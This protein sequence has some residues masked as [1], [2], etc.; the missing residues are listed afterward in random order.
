MKPLKI[1]QHSKRE[2]H[3]TFSREREKGSPSLRQKLPLVIYIVAFFTTASQFFLPEKIFENKMKTRLAAQS[4]TAKE[5]AFLAEQEPIYILP[6]YTMNGTELVGSNMPKLRAL[7]RTEVALWLA[8]LL[9]KQNKCSIVIPDWL[10]VPFL[11]AK[12]IE[13][14][15]R[16][17]RVSE[18]PWH[19]IPTSKILLDVCS[20]DFIDSP[21]EL[22]S[23]IQDLR[24]IRML[25][26]RQGF[27]MIDDEY[28]ELTGLSL[29]EIN[30]IRP[31]L[32]QTMNTL[33]DL[34]KVTLWD[35]EGEGGSGDKDRDEESEEEEEEEAEEAEANNKTHDSSIGS[36]SINN[37]VM[38]NI[39]LDTPF[40][41]QNSHFSDDVPGNASSAYNT[42]TLT[43]DATLVEAAPH[44]ISKRRRV[45]HNVSRRHHSG[46]D[47]SNANS[48]AINSDSDSDVEYR[49]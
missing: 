42:S 2:I 4:L 29:M 46:P 25:K 9:K 37:S 26:T 34:R 43:N 21:H 17:E 49:H 40:R 12:Y 32:L 13:E 10:S 38:D 3:A 22:R 5:I 1:V 15:Q 7:Q 28:L 31:F 39:Q 30:E 35:G 48:S 23:L 33:R 47:E 11:K 14:Q 18:L 36:R 45:D 19:W 16:K 41:Q 44:P 27:A 8:V 20:D 6:R 24:E